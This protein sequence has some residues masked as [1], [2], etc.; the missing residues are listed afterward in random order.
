MKIV[1]MIDMIGIVT[2]ILMIGL[3]ITMILRNGNI[4]TMTMMILWLMFTATIKK[5]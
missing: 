2:V 1:T 5:K 4:G 3:I